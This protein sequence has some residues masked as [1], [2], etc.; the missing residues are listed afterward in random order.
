MK[1]LSIAFLVVAAIVLAALSGCTD[2]A[3]SGPTAN[4]GS[5]TVTKYVSVGNSLT[6]GYQANALYASAQAYSYPNLIAQQLTASG[7]T[8]GA[9]QQPL[10]TDPGN[11]DPLTGKAARYRIIGWTAAGP[12]IGPA[13]EAVTSLTPPVLARPFDNLGI[14]GI[15]LVSFMDTTATYSAPMSA[16][17][18]RASGGLPKSVFRQVAALHPDLVTFWL[19]AN[20]VLGYATSGGV[21]PSAPTPTA[22]FGFLYHQ[23][24][25]TLRKALP[26]AK[27]VVAN[28]PDVRSIPFFNTIGPMIAAEIPAGYKLYYQRGNFATVDSTVLTGA[29]AP[30]ITLLGSTYAAYLGK[31]SGQ[32]GGKFYRDYPTMPVALVDTNYPFGFTKK[33]PWPNLLV[34]DSDEQ[35]IAGA[36]VAAFNGIIATEAAAIGAGVVDFNTIFNNIKAH[37]Y[38]VNGQEFTADY[39][40]GGIFSLD[41]VHPSDRGYGIV[42]NEYIKVMNAKFGMSVPLVNVGSLPG[43]D[44]PL[45]KRGASM[46]PQL[47]PN[48]FS[49]FNELFRQSVE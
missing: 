41:G 38:N 37:G 34:L 43:L 15:P 21:N 36:S 17:I 24:L 13:G 5:T 14:P 26:T 29:N 16:Y 45:A 39:V 48:A 20:D 6:A 11:P 7:A 27:I 42:A 4:L 32:G 22:A 19:G 9:F 28:I 23:A 25:D 30:L 2:S 40:S 10:W 3:P 1:Q 8:I 12:I 46:M 31:G 44:A 49:N 18:L 47:P 35:A 33:N